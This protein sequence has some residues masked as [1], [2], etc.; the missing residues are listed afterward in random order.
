VSFRIR[1]LDPDQFS[2]L[3]GL[4]DTELAALGARRCVVDAKP[5]FPDRIEVRDLEVGETAILL[6]FEHLPVDT[7][8]RSR[9][10]IFVREGVSQ[11]CDVLNEI[12][13]VLRIRTISLRAFSEA[14]EMIDADLAEGRDLPPLIERFLANPETAYLHAHYAKRGC[15]AALV[16]RA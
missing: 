9:H 8:Y 10:A 1:G 5:G 4:S 15:Y 13:D 3:N 12:P 16:T 14:G 11:A 7:P 6:N 2:Y